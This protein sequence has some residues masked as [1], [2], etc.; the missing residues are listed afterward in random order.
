MKFFFVIFV[1]ERA[2]VCVVAYFGENLREKRQKLGQKQN[3][4]RKLIEHGRVYPVD[5]KVSTKNK[6]SGCLHCKNIF[7]KKCKYSKKNLRRRRT[8]HSSNKTL[9][10]YHSAMLPN[11]PFV[12]KHWF[13]KHDSLIT[14][15]I[16]CT[17]SHFSTSRQVIISIVLQKVI[18]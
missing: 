17:G 8:C 6:F 11:L 9:K 1:T 15:V 18:F 2:A 3:S 14:K 7:R 16:L 13:C 4:N 10:L 12:E 5:A